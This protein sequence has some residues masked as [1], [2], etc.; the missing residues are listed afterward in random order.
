MSAIDE[1]PR[2]DTT[3]GA[4]VI[5]PPVSDLGSVPIWPSWERQQ[6]QVVRLARRFV[7]DLINGALDT[8][9]RLD[10]STPEPHVDWEALWACGTGS[11]SIEQEVGRVVMAAEN[12]ARDI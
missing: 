2:N 4:R 7:E 3:M 8:R 6:G 11:A 10:P 1:M 12:L 9:R 5:S